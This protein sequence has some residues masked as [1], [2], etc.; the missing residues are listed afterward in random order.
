MDLLNSSWISSQAFYPTAAVS[1]RVYFAA[2]QAP[3]VLDTLKLSYQQYVKK[4]KQRNGPSEPPPEQE[5]PDR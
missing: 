4:Y 1:C 5:N 3:R 2:Q